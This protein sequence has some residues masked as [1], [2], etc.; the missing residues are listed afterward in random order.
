MFRGCTNLT[1]IRL[2][3]AG[4]KADVASSVFSSWVMNVANTGTFYY[5]GE[6]TPQNFDL[7]SGW[8]KQP[9]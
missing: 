1:S 7:P 2:G 8:T 3:Y 6:D 4:H 5:S 9:Y